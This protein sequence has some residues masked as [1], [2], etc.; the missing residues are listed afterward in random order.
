MV[1]V[2]LVIPRH[3]AIVERGFSLH[4]N[5]KN[6][7][8]NSLMVCTLDSLMRV[9]LMAPR[10]LNNFDLTS[11]A[12]IITSEGWDGKPF[13][14]LVG[15]LQQEVSNLQIPDGLL[16]GFDADAD[17][18]FDLGAL[19]E[20]DSDKESEGD[21]DGGESMMLAADFLNEED[22]AGLPGPAEGAESSGDDEDMVPLMRLGAFLRDRAAGLILDSAPV[23]E[24]ED[25]LGDVEGFAAL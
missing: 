17:A 11:A 2:F 22:G 3:T 20:V 16:E 12:K 7:L 5:I 23:P 8:R 25:D 13:H 19:Q 6:R 10:P 1:F 24:P 4:R 9:S 14:L 18:D 15:K 21:D